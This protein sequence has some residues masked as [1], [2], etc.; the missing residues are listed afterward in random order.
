MAKADCKRRFTEQMVER[1]RAPKTGRAEYADE[2]A[3]GLV[4]RVTDRG[5]KS[6]SVIYKV[7][8]EGGVSASGR[9]LRGRQ[10]RITLGLWP[11]WR[12]AKARDETRRIIEVVTEGR[13]PAVERRECN[14]VRH[15]NTFEAV[16][17]RYVDQYA[18]GQLKHWKTL[19]R[20]L[21]IHVEPKWGNRPL[22]DI[23]RKDVHALLDEL[24]AM[25]RVGTAREVRKYL[26]GMFNWALNRE[27]VLDSPM[28]GLKRDEL[29]NNENAGRK[30]DDAELRAIWAAALGL[31]Y[32]F[33][34][35]YRLLILTGQRRNEWANAKRSEINED[36]RWLEVPRARFKGARDH[37]VPLSDPAWAIVEKLPEFEG[38][39]LMS[40][41]AGKVPVAGFSKAKAELDRLALAALRKQTGDPKAELLPYR[42]HDFRVTCESR[43][44]QLGYNQ[45]TRDAVLGHAK[46][47]L[48]KTYNKHNYLEEKRAALTGYAEHIMELVRGGP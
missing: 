32:P 44:A 11:V 31:G 39:F 37:I 25:D 26:S 34:A 9:L 21:Q 28:H 42:V 46:P 38:D 14:V 6:F 24:V 30:L 40:T 45:E 4:L 2:V 36:E 5:A 12:L 29:A 48:Q 10:H 8:G 3:P 41:R 22:R 13:D 7:P 20:T 1:L 47:G 17:N 18:K 33:G 16:A 27:I 19:Q 23:R 43:L 15:T 35:M